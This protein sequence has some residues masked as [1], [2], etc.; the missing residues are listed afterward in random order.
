MLN[1]KNKI[2]V[3]L[4]SL[5]TL[6]NSALFA[7]AIIDASYNSQNKVL[8]LLV[9]FEGQTPEHQFSLKWGECVFADNEMS[10]SAR[11]VD[12]QGYEDAGKTYEQRLAIPLA[13]L[14]CRPANLTIRLGPR[15]HATIRVE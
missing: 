5:I 4:F 9:A 13:G 3:V 10:I 1:I 12:H 6:T 2:R 15:S 8:S 11:L 14:A 7:G